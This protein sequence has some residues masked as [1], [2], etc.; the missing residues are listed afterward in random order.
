VVAVTP[1]RTYA[2][3]T[4]YESL[5][6]FQEQKPATLSPLFYENAALYTNEMLDAY[7]EY[8]AMYKRIS[9]GIF[10]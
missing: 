10:S 8:K 9:E 7:M 3:L 4:K 5:R 6:S 1:Q 2:I